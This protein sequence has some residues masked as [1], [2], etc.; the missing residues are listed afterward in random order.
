MLVMP[1][2][3]RRGRHPVHDGHAPADQRKT[4]RREIDDGSADRC[5][6]GEPGLDRMPVGGGDIEGL[7]GNF[8]AGKIRDQM[9]R[10]IGRAR[11]RAQRRKPCAD[12]KA[13]N[14]Q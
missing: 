11:G 3:E 4:L 8:G 14:A 1:V 5:A 7:A 9:L 13:Q 6:V 2:D 12:R 10:D